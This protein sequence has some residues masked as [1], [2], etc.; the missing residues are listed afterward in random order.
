MA[1]AWS[2]STAYSAGAIVSYNGLIYLRS[3]FPASP[4]SGTPPN[5]EMSV[6]SKGDD[7]R[8]W[9]ISISGSSSPTFTTSYF[10]LIVPTID[11]ATGYQDFEYSGPINF[12]ESAY[13]P[14]DGISDLYAGI[15]PLG[16]SVAY[17]QFVSNPSPDPASPV[18][19][20]D[21]CGIALQQ[22]QE[23]F[24]YAA[25]DAIRLDPATKPRTYHVFLKFN[26]P[27]YFRRVFTVRKV[28][29]KTTAPT[30]PPT[31]PPVPDVYE[32]TYESVT[33]TDKN[34]LIYEG[35]G[36]PIGYKIEA[37]SVFTFDVPPDTSQNSYQ[38][39]SVVISD[40]SS[41]D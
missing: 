37:N 1:S 16:S 23:F 22:D 24:V 19:P 10:R 6:D 2:S 12:Q 9:T 28:I 39:V 21:K 4:T 14:F 5:Q 3:P 40:V 7:I 31:V 25:V 13:G 41:N 26:H 18:C 35:G 29:Q 15:P 30:D 27:L 34:Y 8:T 20:K 17:D 32:A 36:F 33:P 38:L 11:P